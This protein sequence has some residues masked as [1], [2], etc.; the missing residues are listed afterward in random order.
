MAEIITIARP[1][2][3]AVF[4]LARE[5]SAFD[6]WSQMLK[7]LDMVV[8]DERVARSI[9]DP[10][11]TAQQVEGLVLGVCGEQ[12]D[13]AG[14]NFVQVLVQNDR[15]MVVPEIR[16]LFEQL[17]LEHEG[18][19]ET[20]IHSAFAI[21]PAQVE[22]MVR[23]IEAK[24][25]RKVRAEVRIDPQLIGGVKIVVGDKVFDAT[26]RGKLDAMSAALTR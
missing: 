26:V 24:Y 23:K 25:Q 20:E 21:E 22:Q 3:E 19:L 2:A 9:T 15:L 4:R 17:K 7:L 8:T 6:Q 5:K 10:N 1:Y 16:A 14:R 11:V 12:L 18:V 13:G